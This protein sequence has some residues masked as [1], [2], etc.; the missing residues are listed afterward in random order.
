MLFDEAAS[1]P[2]AVVGR[3][4][5][6]RIHGLAFPINRTILFLASLL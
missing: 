4:L 3:Q 2:E 1:A 6:Q 5:L